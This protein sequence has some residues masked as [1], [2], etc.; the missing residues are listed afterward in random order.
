MNYMNANSG[1]VYRQGNRWFMADTDMEEF[2]NK[3]IMSMDNPGINEELLYLLDDDEKIDRQLLIDKGDY[4]IPDV[5]KIRETIANFRQHFSF[6]EAEEKAII[7][8][9][10]S[11]VLVPTIT[12]EF[13]ERLKE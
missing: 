8:R 3:C 7:E 4:Y 10:S 12:E 6:S 2:K 13:I 11:L 1:V 9:Y 5:S